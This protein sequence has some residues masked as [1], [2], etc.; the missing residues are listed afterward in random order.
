MSDLTISPCFKACGRKQQHGTDAHSFHLLQSMRGQVNGVFFLIY[1]WAF[2]CIFHWNHIWRQKL[3]LNPSDINSQIPK[4]FM[5]MEDAPLAL[6]TARKYWSFISL[7]SCS[8]GVLSF[9]R[10]VGT[11]CSMFF[12]DERSSGAML[13]KSN[14]F[15]INSLNC[16]WETIIE[17]TF[18]NEKKSRVFSDIPWFLL[19]I[20]LQYSSKTV[21][22]WVDVFLYLLQNQ[23]D[24]LTKKICRSNLVVECV[25]SFTPSYGRKPSSSSVFWLNKRKASKVCNFNDYTG[26]TQI[27][28]R[29]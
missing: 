28:D 16:W 17:H 6:L 22:E 1:L 26:S 15:S 13:I 8:S 9:F 27:Q 4:T 18:K 24:Y 20:G 3:Q 10:C 14:P 25:L 12:S 7:S 5:L 23:E 2:E 21:G 11:I 19:I 29:V